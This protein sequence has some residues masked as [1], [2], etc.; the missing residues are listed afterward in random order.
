MDGVSDNA[1][2][3]SLK[4]LDDVRLPSIALGQQFCTDFFWWS[5]CDVEY[6]FSS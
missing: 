4:P 1:K 6:G 2:Y 5:S 3:S